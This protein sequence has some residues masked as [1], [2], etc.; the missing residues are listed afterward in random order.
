MLARNQ[1]LP[2][3]VRR[4]WMASPSSRIP[5]IPR[6]GYSSYS[7]HASRSLSTGK[8]GQDLHAFFQ[9]ELEE[10]DSERISFFGADANQNGYDAPV[11]TGGEQHQRFQRQLHELNEQEEEDK[12]DEATSE[13]D[14][15]LEDMYAEREALFDFSD[16]EKQAWGNP[17]GTLSPKLLQEIQAARERPVESSTSSIES[18]SYSTT[19]PTNATSAATTSTAD[20]PHDSFSHV[21]QDGSSI[22]MVDV[23]PKTVTTRTARAQ[24][25]VVLPPEVLKAF[26]TANTDELVGPKGPIFST[27]KIAGIMAAK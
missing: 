21:S 26:S 6:G 5:S 18:S 23:G 19:T 15:G 12:S 11:T 7:Y 27:A 24:T 20:H 8:S 3:L 10:L 17:Q 9:Q 22:H 14:E 4:G 2:Q 16:E 13:Y 25:K 1:L